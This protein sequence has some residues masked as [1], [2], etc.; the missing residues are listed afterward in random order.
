[1]K[2]S[3]FG[4]NL[5]TNYCLQHCLKLWTARFVT[6]G[7]QEFDSVS[8]WKWYKLCHTKAFARL[9]TSNCLK[10]R[11]IF[12]RC[13]SVTKLANNLNYRSAAWSNLEVNYDIP[14]LDTLATPLILSAKCQKDCQKSSRQDLVLLN[15]KYYQFQVRSSKTHWKNLTFLGR[16]VVPRESG[17]PIIVND[18][19][20]PNALKDCSLLARVRSSSNWEVL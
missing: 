7:L 17:S 10:I 9:T 19:W 5:S 3:S 15:T 13:R 16:F 20:Q 8:I 2:L 14:R 4:E 1:M 6:I 12:D 18:F 11:V